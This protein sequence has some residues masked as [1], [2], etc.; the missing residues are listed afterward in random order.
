MNLVDIS[1]RSFPKAQEFPELQVYS[2]SKAGSVLHFVSL[3]PYWPSGQAL[4]VILALRFP[5]VP[6][7]VEGVS[8]EIDGR[9]RISWNSPDVHAFFSKSLRELFPYT[10]KC[11][12]ITI[13]RVCTV[14]KL[15]SGARDRNQTQMLQRGTWVCSTLG[16]MSTPHQV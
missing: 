3:P 9:G 12:I 13:F 1:N 6:K 7:S 15:K 16:N 11:C 14:R 10:I 8:N 5:R 4:R 2:P